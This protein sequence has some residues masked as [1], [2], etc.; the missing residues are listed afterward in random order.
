MGKNN[1]FMGLKKMNNIINKT[2]MPKTEAPIAIPII[3]NKLFEFEVKVKSED[4][5]GSYVAFFQ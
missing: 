4:N 5:V 3:S 1:I 2:K